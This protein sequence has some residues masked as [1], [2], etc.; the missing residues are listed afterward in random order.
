MYLEGD[1]L[2][3]DLPEDDSKAVYIC[4]WAV[5]HRVQDLRSKP[6]AEVSARSVIQHNNR[7]ANQLRVPI[8][9]L[10]LLREFWSA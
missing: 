9:E 1:R 7:S 8:L 4:S 10:K 5:G 6:G 2:C 3:E